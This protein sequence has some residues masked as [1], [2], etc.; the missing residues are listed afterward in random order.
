MDIGKAIR[1]TE[2]NAVTGERLI[3]TKQSAHITEERLVRM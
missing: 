3:S 2:D 1:Y